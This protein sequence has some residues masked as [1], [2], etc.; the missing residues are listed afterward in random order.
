MMRI[1]HLIPFLFALASL[2]G[3]GACSRQ[4]PQPAGAV[5]LTLSTVPFETRATTPGTT[6]PEDGGAIVVTGGQPDLV[7]AI[8]D[9]NGDIIA[10]YP[11]QN[12]DTAPNSDCFSPHSG[13]TSAT[14]STIRFV[15]LDAGTYS[16]WAV[17]NQGGLWTMNKDLLT[18]TKQSELQA[19]TFNSTTPEILN[20]RMPLSAYGTL[21]VNESLNGQANLEL[22]RCVGK[23]SYTFKNETTETLIL[24]GCT[25]TLKK[26]NPS[27]GYL[28]SND[29]DFVTG[30]AG[31]LVFGPADLSIAPVNPS[32]G[33]D[34][35]ASIASQ[36]LVFP[37]IA[38]AQEVGS[39]YLCDVSFTIGE[40][41][42]SFEDMP[43]HD[44]KS[45]D[46]QAVG[47]NQHL[48]IETRIN[49]GDDISFNFRVLD[50][51]PHSEVV[52]FH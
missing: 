21:T 15:G 43:V 48:Q 23:V 31:D 33:N 9:A 41:A 30:N 7:I 45:G 16:V 11:D 49:K 27:Q 36:V 17:A 4:D 35:S 24:S 2:A 8:A 52:F 29:P 14:E 50:W 38:P 46:I 22:L 47:R 5:A 44:N 39:R 10:W 51:T 28:F 34:G 42:Y 19:L 40:N 1:Q 20:G 3:A 13:T 6:G 25:V 32:S 12:G 26:M 18:C 37:S